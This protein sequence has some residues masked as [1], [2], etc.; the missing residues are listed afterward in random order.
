MFDIQSILNTRARPSEKTSWK[1]VNKD[2]VIESPIS[3]ISLAN[4]FAISAGQPEL[5]SSGDPLNVENTEYF[6]I[7]IAD[8]ESGVPTGVRRVLVKLIAESL[9]IKINW[10]SSCNFF[11]DVPAEKHV[12]NFP[13]ENIQNSP[14]KDQ[15]TPWLYNSKK[16]PAGAVSKVPGDYQK[17][18]AGHSA[19]Q[20]DKL[21]YKLQ[22]WG[23]H[24]CFE[25]GQYGDV[26]K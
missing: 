1:F 6:N 8:L 15:V 7:K 21:P 4:N 3:K 14:I 9:T 2:N 16:P 19:E 25:C 11:L 24:P 17:Y 26:C 5:A 23:S 12:F 22:S 18:I 10:R 20:S 13:M